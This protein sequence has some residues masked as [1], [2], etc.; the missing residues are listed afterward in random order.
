MRRSGRAP[1]LGFLALAMLGVACAGKQ[2]AGEM[3][4]DCY[5]D[6]DCKVGLVCVPTPPNSDDRKCSND[7]TSLASS[8]EGPPP[9]AGAPV[10]DAAT[11]VDDAGM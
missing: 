8:V 9:D 10:D 11:P 3:G 4:D 2:P 6:E 7:V 5:R 1:A